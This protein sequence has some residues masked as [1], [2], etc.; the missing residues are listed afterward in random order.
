MDGVAG[1]L[2]SARTDPGH[3][4]VVFGDRRL[5]YAEAV[6]RATRLANG[7][8]SLGIRPGDR[9]GILLYNC[10]EFL[11]GFLRSPALGQSR[12]R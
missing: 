9:V 3:D 11:E 4:C 7:L 1:L 2:A 6:A 10:T 5:S 8:S 12:F